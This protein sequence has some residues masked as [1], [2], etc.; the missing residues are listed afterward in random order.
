MLVMGG[1]GKFLSIAKW[2][3]HLRNVCSCIK[4]A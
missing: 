1:G 3:Y 2:K 4:I